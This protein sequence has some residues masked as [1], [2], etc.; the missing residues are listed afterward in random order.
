MTV[1]LLDLASRLAAGMSF[2]P[3]DA[4]DRHAAFVQSCRM[5]DGGYRGR[6]GE[7]DLYY[8]SFALRSLA[9]IDRL[10]GQTDVTADFLS[11]FDPLACDVIDMMNWLASALAV[12]AAGGAIWSA[13][14]P[15]HSP[16]ELLPDL[17][18]IALTT[19]VLAKRPPTGAARC[20][21]AFLPFSLINLSGGTSPTVIG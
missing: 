18:N 7:S 2:L 5:P 1:Y 10:H 12:Q 14:G 3:D 15:L 21:P 6:E 20:T 4:R 11:Q 8:T 17:P 19:A 9:M 13:M 16:K